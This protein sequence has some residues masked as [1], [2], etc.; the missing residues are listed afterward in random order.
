ME[1]K[2]LAFAVEGLEAKEDDNGRTVEGFASVFNNVDSYSDIVMPGAFAKSI[3]G[4]KPAMLW[5]HNSGQPIGVWDE[6]EEQKKG[7]YVK[8]RILPTTAGNDAYTLVKAGAVTGM[9]IGY[10]ARKWETD[11][12]KGIRRLTE[13]ELY[14]VSLVTFPANE[15]AQITRVKSLDGQ[16][17]TERDFEEF[18]RDVGQL[19]QKE[20][21]I[22]VSDG[23]KALLK[24]RDGGA[25]EHTAWRDIAHLFNQIKA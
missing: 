10:S 22:V 5:Q 4:R 21:K 23:Y 6:M 3:K 7:L 18:L 16:F 17:M 1:L 25:E 8:G 11:T 24:H 14:E 12:D 2:H 19:S 15:K 20:A 13:V 9:S